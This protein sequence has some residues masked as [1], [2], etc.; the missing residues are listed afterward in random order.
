LPNVKTFLVPGE[1]HTMIGAPQGFTSGGVPLP[2]WLR[3]EVEDDPAWGSVG[4]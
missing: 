3:R 4:P 2:E 1:T